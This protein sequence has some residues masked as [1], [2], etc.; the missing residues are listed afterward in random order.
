MLSL[1]RR[2]RKKGCEAHVSLSRQVT[3]AVLK[4]HHETPVLELWWRTVLKPV[5]FS[6][7]TLSVGDLATIGL[8]I[9][10]NVASWTSSLCFHMKWLLCKCLNS[11]STSLDS[12]PATV[13]GIKLLETTC[14]SSVLMCDLLTSLNGSSFSDSITS[15]KCAATDSASV[16]G[17]AD[18]F[19]FKA[20]VVQY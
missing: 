4:D 10:L 18:A 9:T 1:A 11:F 8:G 2:I 12:L 14:Q 16:L 19:V 20:W 15:H 17:C 7:S 5:L 3:Q 6:F 13:I